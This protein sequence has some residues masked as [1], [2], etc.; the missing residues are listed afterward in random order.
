MGNKSTSGLQ[1]DLI[2]QISRETGF[3]RTQVEKLHS[4]FTHLDRGNHGSLSKSDLLDLPE[5][6]MNPLAEQLVGMFVNETSSDRISFSKFTRVL[7][8]FKPASYIIGS[9]GTI[10]MNL[11]PSNVPY[12]IPTNLNRRGANCVSPRHPTVGESRSERMAMDQRICTISDIFKRRLEYVFKLY[13]CDRDGRISFNDL[14]SLV[15]TL[16]G[17][18][19]DDSQL[20]KITLRAF[21]EVDEDN[22]SFIDFEEF[23]KVFDGKDLDDRLAVKFF[24]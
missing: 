6:S 11:R 16:V 2:E 7:S 12:S 14:K 17:D 24:H 5:L 1:E 10:E 18:C 3:T 13:D 4:R 9:N 20:D 19:M 21:V 8:A 15:K 23:C 22:N